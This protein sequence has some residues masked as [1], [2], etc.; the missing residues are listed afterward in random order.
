MNLLAETGGLVQSFRILSLFD[1]HFQKLWKPENLKVIKP[2]TFDHHS[3]TKSTWVLW[4][5]AE[6]VSYIA[7]ALRKPALGGDYMSNTIIIHMS[8]VLTGLPLRLQL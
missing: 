3:E 8:F 1:K 6:M 4:N 2:K 5:D 7:K